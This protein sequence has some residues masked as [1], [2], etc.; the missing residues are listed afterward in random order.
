MICRSVANDRFSVC[1]CVCV[2]RA[3]ALGPSD[4]CMICRS[5]ANDRFMCVCVCVVCVCACSGARLM[6]SYDLQVCG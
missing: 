6:V 3:M 1:V 2:W 5:V 4:G